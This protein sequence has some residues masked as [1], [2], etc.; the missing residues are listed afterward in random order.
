[1]AK[2]QTKAPVAVTVAIHTVQASDGRFSVRALGTLKPAKELAL[3]AEVSGR[4]IELHPE[5]VPGGFVSESDVLLK[6]D[7]R[8]YKLNVDQLQAQL[9]TARVRLQQERSRHLVAKR[10]WQLLGK[11]LKTSK[12]GR[13]LALR[14][15]QLKSAQAAIVA[16]RSNVKKAQ[17]ALERTTIRAPFNAVVRSESVEKGQRVAPGQPIINLMGT[18]YCWVQVAISLSKLSFL[19]TP[20]SQ[21]AIHQPLS[22]G[23]SR[24]R[25]GHVI[26]RLPDVDQ[27]SQ[28]VR[29]I[30]R[31]DDPMGLKT[32]EPRLLMNAS[33]EVSL[34]GIPFENVVRIPRH[35]LR[36]DRNV[37]Q[38]DQDSKLAVVPIT[39]VWRDRDFV[40]ARGITAGTKII[41]SRISGAAAGMKVRTADSKNEKA[42]P[43]NKPN[44][45]RAHTDTKTNV[46]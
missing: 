1:M 39:V 33:V 5:V 42:P 43:R 11:N 8:D 13:S 30:V 20:G 34:E 21:V 16:A 40:L 2:R 31:V 26:R 37:W 10:E 44:G 17:L 25:K 12:S 14:E 22:R 24:I 15:P 6:I 9:Q 18:D 27:G 35:A 41:S 45:P 4:L 19:K 46:Q 38:I 3:Q 28:L 29:L 36:N 7:P 32:K 23:Q